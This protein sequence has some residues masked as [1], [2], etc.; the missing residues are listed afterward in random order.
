M[1]S[2]AAW[3]NDPATREKCSSGG[4][5]FEVAKMLLSQGYSAVGCKYEMS[6]HRAVHFIA[7]S[8]DGYLPS[9]GS[10]YIQSYTKD[11]FRLINYNKRYLITGTPCQIDSFRRLIKKK[12]VEDNFVLL[13]FFCHGVPSMN[14][15]KAYVEY[16]ESF[17][18]PLINVSWRNKKCNGWH[19]SLTM[20]FIGTNPIKAA[21]LLEQG[22]DG[23]LYSRMT[24]GDL[25]YRLFL[26]EFCSGPHCVHNCKYKFDSSAA[27]IRIGDLWGDT[28]I[29]NEQGVSAVVAFTEKGA[30]VISQMNT[31]T[32]MNH[33]FDVVAEGQLKQNCHQKE[34]SSLIQF[35][36]KKR[37]PLDGFIIR[38]ILLSQ[39][40]ITKIKRV[41]QI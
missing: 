28:Y 36:L 18:G 29:D 21:S 11:A 26:G 30:K 34:L 8:L 41:F 7:N 9:M 6:Q 35:F 14:V 2:W 25:F 1:G 31:V 39:R 23:V 17:V 4:F 15:W 33:P 24:R 27:D 5:G 10:K 22:D 40:V 3:S 19:D 37:V 12:G 16:I 20:G 13:D 32:L 38:V